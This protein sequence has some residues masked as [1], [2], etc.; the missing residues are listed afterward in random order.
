MLSYKTYQNDAYSINYPVD[1]SYE[2]VA[3]NAILFS[4]K[5]GTTSYYST[6]SIIAASTKAGGKVTVKSAVNILKKQIST[7]YKDVKFIKTGE[8]ELPQNPK[9]IRGEYFVVTYNYKGVTIKNMQFILSKGDG[10]MIY[11]WGYAAPAKL[12]DN[13][14]PVAKAMYESWSIK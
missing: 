8:V 14:L 7:R 2:Q 5:K 12:Y 9:Q 4:G 13:D 1:W 3:P 11:I 6:V 10:K